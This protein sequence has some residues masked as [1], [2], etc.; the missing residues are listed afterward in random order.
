MSAENVIVKKQFLN[1]VNVDE[2]Q[3]KLNAME[4]NPDMA[5]FKFHLK[6]T[7]IQGGHNRTK[8]NSFFGANKKFSHLKEFDLDV[9]EPEILLG[10]DTGP[11]PVEYLLNA[12]AGCLT[13]TL[14]YHASL[15]GI[16][17]EKLESD[18]EGD[19]DLRGFLAVT[20]EVR[21]GFQNIRVKFKIK[22]N[23]KDIEKLKELSKFSPVFDVVSNGTN[24][25]I[26]IK[27]K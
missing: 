5:N 16:K 20:E 10:E 11:S 17:I 8:I 15:H 1:G 19:I 24:V 14:I 23:E 9:D 21:N 2:L 12:L 22:T 6:N 7:W 25:D 27:R 18:I 13:T 26:Q 3:R 4:T